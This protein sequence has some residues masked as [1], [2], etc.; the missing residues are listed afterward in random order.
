MSR[1]R[2]PV[3]R[4]AVPSGHRV[5]SRRQL[6]QLSLAA[7]LAPALAHL[8]SGSELADTRLSVPPAPSPGSPRARLLG[9]STQESVAMYLYTTAGRVGQEYSAAQLATVAS[10]YDMLTWVYAGTGVAEAVH[11]ANPEVLVTQYF[12][13]TWV[14]DYDQ[15]PGVPWM[16]VPWSY[17]NARESF[18]SHFEPEAAPS[19][20]IANPL[21][22]YGATAQMHQ[23]D[24]TGSPH[25]WLANPY[26][27]DAADP[28]NLDRWVN[29]FAAS[30]RQLIAS[31]AMDG[32]MMDEVEQPYGFP[33]PWASTPWSWHGALLGDLAFI[34]AQLG[35]DLIMFW[36]GIEGDMLLAP[37]HLRDAGIWARP[38]SLDFLRYCDGVQMELFVTSYAGPQ[39]WPEPLWE[40][41]LDLCMTVVRR[42]GVLLAQS[43]ILVEDPVNRMFTLA[44]FHLVKGERSYLS[45]RGGGDFPWFPEWTVELGAPCQTARHMSGYLLLPTGTADIATVEGVAY[46]RRFARGLAVANPS[47]RPTTVTLRRPGELVVASG[48][49]WI[50]TDGELPAGSLSYQPV[51]S[52]TV[53]AQGGALVR[54]A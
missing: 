12:D 40:E 29:Y 13:L 22:G 4:G 28:G 18:F 11:A 35:P 5:L 42:G 7:G 31:S 39:V 46:A 50:G 6:L 14:G 25:E 33:P 24:P 43:P 20:R 38:D 49:G 45:H 48:G 34:R 37:P 44:S 15:V 27:L 26:D 36:N 10:V 3:S 51:T 19:T 8:G 32:I 41:I 1:P 9:R 2:G 47:P 54:L 16:P 53:P 30:A 17:V 23:D 21:F 52:I